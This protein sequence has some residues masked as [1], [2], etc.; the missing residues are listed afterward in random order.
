MHSIHPPLRFTSLI[1]FLCAV[2]CSSDEETQGQSARPLDWTEATHGDD[3][4]PDYDRVFD[5][6]RVQTLK[7][8][9]E[10]EDFAAMT[11]NIEQLVDDSPLGGQFGADAGNGMPDAELAAAACQDKA[12]GDECASGDMPGSCSMAFG[13]DLVCIPDSFQFDF[14]EVFGDGPA[15]LFPEDPLWVP[16]DVEYD[17]LHWPHVGMRYKGN[18]SLSSS[19]G[20]GNGKLPFR[21]TFDRFEDDFPETDD[22]RFFGFKKLTFSSNFSD[23]S[24]LRELLT[25]EVFRDRGVPAAQATFYRVEI[26]TGDGPVYWGLYTM[27]EDPSDGAMLDSQFGG[28]GGN[29]YKPDGLGADWTVFD[30]AGFVKK[31]NETEA[32]FSDVQAAVEA[33]LGDSAEAEWRAELEQHLDVDGFLR[34]LAVNTAILNWDTYGSIAHNYY[35]YADPGLAD[36]LRW[37][38][39]DH[40]MSMA[41]RG[42][43]GSSSGAPR[44]EMFHTEVSEGWPLIRKLM[45]DRVYRERY[46]VLLEQCLEGLL[47]EGSFSA[48]AQELHSLVAPH[49]RAETPSHT[50]VSSPGAFDDSLD[51]EGGL[52]PHMAERRQRLREALGV[53]VEASN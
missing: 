31:T 1:A 47:A 45:D 7:I 41:A 21:L 20:A 8:R 4:A 48:R 10:P 35:L 33:L 52:L 13:D 23:N 40:N 14:E 46:G 32:D 37:V 28:R 16:V 44:D 50:T 51:A 29:L 36:R 43:G 6:S 53:E 26:D 19:V 24:Q 12:E 18:S 25:T 5:A 34:W 15:D 11:E 2:G 38:P 39:W 42:F 27:I 49:V 3:A 30:E 17:E 22:Q 9:I